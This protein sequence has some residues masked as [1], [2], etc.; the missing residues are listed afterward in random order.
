ML[1]GVMKKEEIYIPWVA[2][3]WKLGAGRLDK[4][5]GYSLQPG[6][7]KKLFLLTATELFELSAG[8]SAT[9]VRKSFIAVPDST[10]RQ[11]Q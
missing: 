10:D 11:G 1:I 5:L 9:V 8:H 6:T 7:L 2:V 4:C 3:G